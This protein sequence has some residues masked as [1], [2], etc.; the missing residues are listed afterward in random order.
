MR[1]ADMN[2]PEAVDSLEFSWPTTSLD[3]L[4]IVRMD[5]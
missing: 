3:E 4:S 1:R 5:T 2:R